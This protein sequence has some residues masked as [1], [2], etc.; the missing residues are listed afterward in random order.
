MIKT[1]YIYL[2]VLSCC[3][4]AVNAQTGF[5]QTGDSALSLMEVEVA[6][7]R[8]KLEAA[9]KKQQLFDSLQ[10]QRFMAGD[11]SK[12]L[13]Q[14]AAIHIKT[15]GPANI[16][17]STLRGGNAAQTAVIWNGVNIQNKLL[18]QV[19]LSQL[20]VF[21]FDGASLEYGGSSASW[22]S[23]A[24]SGSLLLNNRTPLRKN[25]SLLLCSSAGSFGALGGGFR[26]SISNG[27]QLSTTRVYVNKA[28]NN[29]LFLNPSLQSQELLQH[30]AFKTLHLMQ[31][32][33]RQIK[34]SQF[35]SVNIWA[36]KN[37][38]ELPDYISNKGSAVQTDGMLR[39]VVRHERYKGKTKNNS[40]LAFL[41]DG[42]RFL[43]SPQAAESR[44]LVSSAIAE[45]DNYRRWQQHVFNYALN[46]SFSFAKSS[47][48][49]AI[50]YQSFASIMAANKFSILSGRII[51]QT[52][53]RHE[54]YFNSNQA[55]TFNAGT[56][57]K[58]KKTILL[59]CNVAKVFRQPTFNELYW[60]PGGKPDLRPEKGY[61]ADGSIVW[62]KQTSRMQ[63]TAE[64]TAF[65]RLINNWILWLPGPA[66]Q[67]SPVN[68]NTVFSRGTET[69]L[70]FSQYNQHFRIVFQVQSSYVLSTV[71]SSQLANDASVGKQLIYTP[72]YSGNASLYLSYK[73]FFA[74]WQQQYTGYRFTSSDNREWLAPYFVSNLRLGIDLKKKHPLQLSIQCNNLGNNTYEVVRG[75]AMPYR[76]YQ[77]QLI[78]HINFNKHKQQDL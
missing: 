74:E 67:P 9:G 8:D 34:A 30:A 26:Y 78:Y 51:L 41:H 40:M 58:M 54:I 2:L 64:G 71:L 62:Q 27:R 36:S 20:P 29:Y 44:A 37:L 24:V 66:S 18:G 42:V 57:I 70:K 16:A 63:L 35:L 33:R 12:L 73:V 49:D 53:M 6:A 47:A 7:Y 43:E 39:S 21:M 23:G 1:N 46:F 68:I 76:N 56:E 14:E 69:R 31:E 38:R 28:Q 60:I 55:F 25:N 4:L 5:V 10:L 48:F 15:Y 59:R 17:T 52:N 72:R 3:C 32:W 45:M 11:L 50:K 65:V 22:G 77:I 13:S 19:D 75:R 61:S